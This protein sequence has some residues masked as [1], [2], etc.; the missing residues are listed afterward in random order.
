M[1]DNRCRFEGECSIVNDSYESD[2]TGSHRDNV[3]HSHNAIPQVPKIPWRSL[4]IIAVGLGILVRLSLYF[5]NRSLWSDEL[6]LALNLRDRAYVELLSALDYDQAAPPLFLWIERFCMQVLGDSEYSLRLYPLLAGIGAL[7]LF[8]RLAVLMLPG[9]TATLA[10]WLFATLKY[11]VSF[12]NELKPYSVD[13]FVSLLLFSL[14][15]GSRQQSFGRLRTV[16]LSV[17][18]AVGIWTSYPA[19]FTLVAAESTVLFANP[20]TSYRRLFQSR[21]PVYGVWIASFLGLFWV[22]VAS[23]LENADLVNSWSSRYP[24]SIVDVV[25]LL[26]ALG[27]FFYRPLGFEGIAEVLAI[28]AFLVGGAVLWR[29]HRPTLLALLSPAIVTLAAAYLHQYPFRERLILFLVPYMVLILSSGMAWTLDVQLRPRYCQ[30][31]GW[32]LAL[33]LLVPPTAQTVSLIFRPNRDIGDR[34]RPLIEH[35]DENFRPQD[36]IYVFS[37]ADTAFNYYTSNRPHLRQNWLVSTIL[38]PEKP[39]HTDRRQQLLTDL[40]RLRGNDRVWLLG[41]DFDRDKGE[42]AL[43]LKDVDLLGTRIELMAISNSAVA[44]YDFSLAPDSFSLSDIEE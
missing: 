18:G 42:L 9:L 34:L 1:T 26:D 44:L 14:L 20:V 39:T 3:S 29:T 11:T 23:A 35:I 27:R 19:V 8:Y 37:A 12:S 33:M 2:I 32:G 4:S 6:G 5:G 25:W 31:L 30:V 7:L 36:T 17:L 13:L 21:L 10:I 41:S 22:S 16:L 43:I 38:L 28:V 40:E 24:S 15:W